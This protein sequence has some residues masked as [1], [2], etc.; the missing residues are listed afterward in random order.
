MVVA[1]HNLFN[2]GADL[3]KSRETA[4][5]L[6]ETRA[7]LSLARRQTERTI[8]TAWGEAKN[9]RAKS[10]HLTN[11]IREK[12]RL[13]NLYI[14]EFTVAKRTLLDI[15]DAA[16]EVFLTE[17]TRTG[18][19]ATADV[20]T[21]VLSVGT[22]QFKGYLNRASGSEEKGKTPPD[23]RDPDPSVYLASWNGQKSQKDAAP[24]RKSFFDMKKE[25]RQNALSDKNA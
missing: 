12:R 20:N 11:L 22:A 3:A 17:A 9:A 24:K 7:R 19:D 15:L 6:T 18:V 10:A 2:G 13:L 21:I 25:S 16:N 5:R 4:K 8:R 14:Q 1:R 23:E